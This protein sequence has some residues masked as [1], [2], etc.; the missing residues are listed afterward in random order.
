MN[1]IC[2]D[3][4]RKDWLCTLICLFF[5]VWLLEAFWYALHMSIK[6]IWFCQC[7]ALFIIHISLFNGL[8]LKQIRVCYTGRPL[9]LQSEVAGQCAASLYKPLQGEG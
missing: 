8:L 4:Y 3:L 5:N 1:A 7:L 9:G 6:G 2:L